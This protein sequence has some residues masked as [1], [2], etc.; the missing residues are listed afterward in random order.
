MRGRTDF[1][2]RRKTLVRT[3]ETQFPN[4]LASLSS[5][6]RR[7]SACASAQASE[8]QTFKAYEDIYLLLSQFREENSPS[9]Q[10]RVGLTARA[11]DSPGQKVEWRANTTRIEKKW[12][13]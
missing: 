11:Y 2:Y 6:P 9:M 12:L 1:Q 10:W 7:P 3:S 4:E 13:W 5:V 8:A